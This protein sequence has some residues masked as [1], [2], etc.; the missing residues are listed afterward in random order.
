MKILM[1]ITLLNKLSHIL[2]ILMIILAYLELKYIYTILN[3]VLWE[4]QRMNLD[5]C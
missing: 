2:E 4:Q 1:S 5:S 3:P